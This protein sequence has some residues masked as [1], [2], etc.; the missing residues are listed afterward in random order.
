[1]IQLTDL[2]DERPLTLPEAAA[3]LGRLTGQKPHEST[4]WR[5]CLKGCK[6][7][8]LESVC[9]GSK[10]YVT[11]PALARFI[12]ARSSA[13]SEITSEI[14]VQ[15]QASPYVTRHSEGRRAEIEAAQRRRDARIGASGPTRYRTPPNGPS[16]SG[17]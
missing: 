4:I 2:L 5:W 6:G 13:A 8:R 16:R 7:V 11:V 17:E 3:Y 15:R 10:R 1:M 14:V 12:A 9:I